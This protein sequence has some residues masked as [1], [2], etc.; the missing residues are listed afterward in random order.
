M[1]YQDPEFGSRMIMLMATAMLVLQFLMVGQKLLKTNIRLFAIQSFF[2]TGI[3][4][5][6][7]YFHHAPHIYIAAG[8]TLVLKVIVVPW[9]LQ[10][11]I[12]RIQIHHEVEPFINTPLSLLIGSGLTLVGY[13][14][15]Q[16][17]R[18]AADSPVSESLHKTLAVAIAIML[19]GF[20]L[21]INRRKA[22]SQVL[23]LL[24]MENGLF[25][26]AI[27]LTYG[28]PLV[29]ELGIFFDVFVAV[30]VFG[31]LVYRIRETFDSM[32]VSKLSDLKG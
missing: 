25:L 27:S 19:I 23:A 14:V 20:Y 8:M 3:A 6:I 4:G 2:L 18:S 13:L 12:D 26:T 29:V 10:R 30:I 31:I 16:P 7:A 9:F 15:V 11:M 28:M 17:F 5:T 24:T 32:D 1:F 22:L 21:M